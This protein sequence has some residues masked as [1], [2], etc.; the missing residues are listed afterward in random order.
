MKKRTMVILGLCLLVLAGC[1]SV[2]ER[3]DRRIAENR[4]L[5]DS[6]PEEIQA[7]VRQGSVE[8][9]FTRDMV[10]L[11]WGPPDHVFTR[12]T[13]ERRATIWGYTRTRYYP[14]RDRMSIPVYFIDGNGRRRIRYHSVWI[15]SETQEEYTVARV[16]FVKGEVIGVEQLLTDGAADAL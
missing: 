3:R 12:V 13:K 7:Q 2:Q 4:E 1:A 9:G 14:Y 16:E 15:N 8:V 10:R 11:A 6:F 5:F